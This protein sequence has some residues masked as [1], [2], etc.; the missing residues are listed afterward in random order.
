MDLIV[1][2]VTRRAPGGVN[3]MEWLGGA[4]FMLEKAACGTLMAA[5]RFDRLFLRL[6]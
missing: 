5:G 6:V 3:C 2:D 4:H 1:S